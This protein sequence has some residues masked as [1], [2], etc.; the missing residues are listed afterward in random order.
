MTLLYNIAISL[1]H[2]AI[3]LASFFNEKAKKWVEGRKNIFQSIEEKINR[4]SQNSEIS[5]IWFHCASLG[6]FEQG[7]PLMEK[8]KN[9][10]FPNGEKIKIFLTFFSPSGYEIKKNYPIA[11]HIFYL[12]LDSRGNAEKFISIVKPSIAIFVK[13]EIWFHYMNELKKRNIP[14]YLIS[15]AFR[16]DHHYFKWYG[17]WFRG[18]LEMFTHIFVQDENSKTLLEKINVNKV[19]VSGD[20]RFDRV[21]ETAKQAEEISLIARFR[22]QKRVFIAGSTWPEDEK[23]ISGITFSKYNLKVIIAPHEI[24]ESHINL[25]IH[26]FSHL[27]T[28]RFSQAN[29][30]NI[31]DADVLIMDNIGLLS[32]LYRYGDMAYVGGAFGRS[33]HN[34]LE[35]SA[36]GLPVLFGPDYH[37]NWEAAALIDRGG[38]FSIGS[39]EELENKINFL[40]QDEMILKIASEM[41]RNF[42]R[43]NTGATGKIIEVIGKDLMITK[44]E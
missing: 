3:I 26:S 28:L 38:A 8:L 25:I 17:S 19:T 16:N 33:L 36:F 13:Y 37:K 4:K 1:Y 23:L 35:P 42:V 10:S 6:E 14:S 31:P 5:T 39:S 15:A 11:D 29:E 41:S 20:T 43:S 2:F 40:L 32:R 27:K 9:L 12:P 18:M 21:Y 24:H 34:I 7:R 44:K 22:G 30:K